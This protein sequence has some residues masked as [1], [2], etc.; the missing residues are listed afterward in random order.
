MLVALAG[1]NQLLFALAA[2]HGLGHTVKR[3]EGHR[4][5][6]RARLLLAAATLLALNVYASGIPRHGSSGMRYALCGN[7]FTRGAAE[8]M[9]AST[10]AQVPHSEA[11]HSWDDLDVRWASAPRHRRRNVVVVGLETARADAFS[12]WRDGTAGPNTPFMEALAKRGRIVELAYTPTPNTVKAI[13]ALFCGLS[14]AVTMAWSEFAALD[15]GEC[16]PS[17]LRQAG[18]GTA[19]FTGGALK[20]HVIRPHDVEA[21]GFDHSVGFEELVKMDAHLTEHFDPVNHL[22]VEDDAIIAPAVAW[23]QE[24]AARDVPFFMGLFT[25][26]THA[27]YDTPRSFEPS[28]RPGGDTISSR[29]HSTV[30]YTD[31]FLG[32][33][34]QQLEQAGLG[35]DTLFVVAGDHGEMFGEHGQ[36]QHGSSLHEEALRVPLV[37]AGPD[38]GPPG[39]PIQGLRSL[40]DVAPT[41]LQWVG[42]EVA[43]GVPLRSGSSLLTGPGHSQLS[44]FS[45]F[46]EDQL[47][48]RFA[49]SLKIIVDL[50]SGAGE[51]FDLATDQREQHD[52]AGQHAAAFAQRTSELRQWKARTNQVVAASKERQLTRRDRTKEVQYVVEEALPSSAKG[53]YD[54][55]VDAGDRTFLGSAYGCAPCFA[56]R[57]AADFILTVCDVGLSGGFSWVLARRFS[58]FDAVYYSSSD[59]RS[60]ECA[61]PPTTGWRAE[62]FAVFRFGDL[63]AKNRQELG[64]LGA[65][66]RRSKLGAH[67]AGVVEKA[68]APAVVVNASLYDLRAPGGL[69]P[70]YSLAFQFTRSD[71]GEFKIRPA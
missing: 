50:Q 46:N 14:P 20:N 13:V 64:S 6:S 3:P 45:F 17:I 23:A 25:V 31:R 4:G 26:T 54:T 41:L 47:A 28:L 71:D 18:Y 70:K 30:E 60:S 44:F 68:L 36:F 69:G 1:L 8:L 9:M 49:S 2:A 22:G 34:F 7:V 11:P 19:V 10:A 33:L 39:T 37:L 56:Q 42:A 63:D 55:F 52:I 12:P 43:N 51:M 66:W 53:T 15:L 27:P 65:Q 67:L 29:Y 40:L 5:Y 16:V 38:I 59:V 61:T 32:K 62:S 57:D 58:S 21:M 48:M 24:Q 35:S